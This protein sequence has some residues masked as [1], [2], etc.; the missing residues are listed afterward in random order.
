MSI[1]IL[2]KNYNEFMKISA[3]IIARNEEKK[4]EEALK[5]L[6]FVDEIVVVLDRTIDSTESICKKFT[7]QI[8]KGKWLS[9]G[10]RRN[11][12]IQKCR[13]SWILEIDADEIIQESLA[14]EIVETVKKTKSDYF[15]I[16]LINY[17]GKKPIKFGWMACLAPDGKFCLFKKKSKFWIDGKVHPK[18]E[19]KGKKGEE[20]TN[21]IIHKMASNISALLERFNRNTSLNAED[22]VDQEKDVSKFLSV[23]KIISRFIKCYFSRK[24]YLSGGIGLLISLLSAFYP[25]ISAMKTKEKFY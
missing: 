15:Y 8:Y 20:F 12:G 16:R 25:F 1:Y 7:N 10:R 14:R 13:S 24:A 19:L 22:W 5:A 23:R 17:V 9:E 4:I 18:Y 3:L 6:H 2:K 21:Q 11:F